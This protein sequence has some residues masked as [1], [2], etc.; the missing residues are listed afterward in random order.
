LNK[1]F[2][3]RFNFF[4]SLDTIANNG[5]HKSDLERLHTDYDWIRAFYKH[6]YESH[7]KTVAMIH[8]VLTWRNDFEA[9]SKIFAHYN[10]INLILIN[11][12][13]LVIPGKT[14]FPEDLL[15]KGGLFMKN[16]D[17]NCIPM[18]KIKY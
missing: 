18:C 16:E 9:N 11:I 7:D 10:L 6:G 2:D 14:P 1:F 4:V 5:Y 17:I 12:L 13:D 8:D 3:E 15:K